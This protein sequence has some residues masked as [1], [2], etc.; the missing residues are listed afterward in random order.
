MNVSAY[1][2]FFSEKYSTVF[3]SAC[4]DGVCSEEE[5]AIC[6]SCPSGEYCET[7][8]VD[9]GVC[10]TCGNG[11][12]EPWLEESCETCG[13]DCG[14]CGCGDGQCTTGEDCSSCQDDCGTCFCGDGKCT[15]GEDCSSCEVDCE[16][17]LDYCGDGFCSET[18]SCDS[19]PF[20]CGNC[21]LCDG[22]CTESDCI[23]C[24]SDCSD[25]SG[26]ESSICSDGNLEEV[27]GV[28]GDYRLE[29]LE[30]YINDYFGNWGQ[31]FGRGDYCAQ[32]KLNGLKISYADRDNG[33]GLTSNKIEESWTC[34]GLNGGE[35][36]HC[37]IDYP[38]INGQ[39]AQPRVIFMEQHSNVFPYTY[40]KYSL[41]PIYCDQ[42]STRNVRT[43]INDCPG[44]ANVRA[45]NAV[46]WGC[47]G[48]HGG[49]DVNCRFDYPSINGECGSAIGDY[50]RHEKFPRGDYCSVGWP[51][52]SSS[53]NGKSIS[54]T[55]SP[56]GCGFEA[57]CVA[58]LLVNDGQCGGASGTYSLLER[59]PRGD[60]CL[61]G[62][63]SGFP[64]E[65]NSNNVASWTCTGPSGSSVSCSATREKEANTNGAC[66]ESNRTSLNSADS[67]LGQL[68]SPSSI[69][70]NLIITPFEGGDVLS[71]GC[72]GSGPGATDASCGAISLGKG[73]S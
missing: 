50:A 18:E 60:A 13:V 12:C 23:N 51:K 25:T 19:C 24:P 28:C 54:W 64:S 5:I 31:Y 9:C 29:Y 17:C 53:G 56:F 33:R 15:M 3:F 14:T 65:V 46:R 69:V 35:D 39:C 21:N 52:F 41:I 61:V 32:G 38:K 34:T 1:S 48:V 22:V 42:G 45:I 6:N 72:L 26:S 30:D 2:A 11:S 40:N 62:T 37:W 4:G 43:E 66:G 68:C 71:W 58:N 59:F 67:S 20:D 36:E 27:H 47:D 7:C 44:R 16:A 70:S 57:N 10:N 73:F 55:C 63:S 49:V 8:E